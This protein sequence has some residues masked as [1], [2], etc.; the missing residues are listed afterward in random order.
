MKSKLHDLQTRFVAAVKGD[1]PVFDLPILETND[2]S[3]EVRMGVYRY[4]YWTRIEE[5]LS[6]DFPRLSKFLDQ[7]LLLFNFHDLVRDLMTMQKNNFP[8]LSE[9]SKAFIQHTLLKNRRVSTLPFELRRDFS[10]AMCTDY[11][12]LLSELNTWN[13]LFAEK[14]KYALRAEDLPNYDVTQIRI[15]WNESIQD[16]DS[17][18]VFQKAMQTRIIDLA[19]SESLGFEDYAIEF[20]EM[21]KQRSVLL[22]FNSLT[23]E[24]G[25]QGFTP[26]ATTAAVKFLTE[27]ELIFFRP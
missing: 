13:L 26:E 2:V 17:T 19:K 14:T 27:N 7:T 21:L 22:N 5:S 8:N 11:A 20:V 1:G 6:E 18:I 4:A 15:I 12:V 16:F 3:K 10:A 9:L 25:R 23:D 24:F